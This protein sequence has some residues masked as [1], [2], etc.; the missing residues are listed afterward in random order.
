ML[1]HYRIDTLDR[2]VSLRR[3]YMLLRRL[4]A[5]TWPD[6]ES[7]ASWSVEAYLLAL[8]ADRVGALI[9]VTQRAAGAKSA[10]QPKPVPRPAPVRRPSPA[11]APGARTGSWSA[12]ARGLLGQK[13]V[14]VNR[15]V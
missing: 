9:Y 12:A 10:R 13:G 3:I 14:E 1:A 15:Y 2:R 6:T 5:G 7:P 11:V 4:P 8:L